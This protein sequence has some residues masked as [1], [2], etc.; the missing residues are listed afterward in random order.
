LD[1]IVLSAFAAGIATNAGNAARRAIVESLL[2]MT[3]LLRFGG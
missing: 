2:S 1:E 3:Y